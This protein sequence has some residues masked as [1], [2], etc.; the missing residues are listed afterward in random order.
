MN[1]SRQR[2]GYDVAENCEILLVRENVWSIPSQSGNGSYEVTKLDG[3][4]TCSCKDFEFRSVEVGLC[5]HCFALDYYLQLQS[6]VIN[7]VEQEIDRAVPKEITLCPECKSPTVINYGRR[8]K[9]VLKQ[10]MRCKDCGRQ[11]RSQEEAFAKLQTDPRMISLI[12]SMH[13][14][15]VSLRGICATL[16]ETYGI[17]VSHQTVHNYLGRY[18]KLLSDYM[19][20]LKPQFSGNVNVDELFV[21]IDGQMKY[22]FAALDPNTRFL[23]CTILSQK[24]DHK[25][26]RQLFHKLAEVTG[27]NKINQTIKTI[28][29]DA[30]SAHKSAYKAEFINDVRTKTENPPKHNFGAGIRGQVDNCIMERVN[31]TLRGRERNYR[32][33][34]VDDTPMIP[35][36]AAY[37]NLV[38]EH[39]AINKT[40]AMAAG[41]DLNLGHD[42]WNGLIKRAHK[43]KKT[44]G[45]VRVWERE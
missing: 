11:F 44:G 39:Q 10:I 5:K 30:L 8:G 26:A 31:N 3:T 24:R 35:L 13:C 38:R 40:P 22:L 42:K 7:D 17:K 2:R 28:T 36:F 23:L 12:L 4:F 21:K 14:R 20:S 16:N 18:E 45:R 1:E 6:K 19:N 41:I 27:H 34:N 37:Y 32:G 9:R 15:N 43:Y 25:G 29:S 33:L